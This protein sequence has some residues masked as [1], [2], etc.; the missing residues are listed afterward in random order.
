MKK[1]LLIIVLSLCSTFVK[2]ESDFYIDNTLSEEKQLLNVFKQWEQSYKTYT[3]YY[4]TN[5]HL[6]GDTD[7]E[8]EYFRLEGILY[9][10]ELFLASVYRYKEFE[11]KLT[12]L[13]EKNVPY[14]QMSYQKL[15]HWKSWHQGALATLNTISESVKNKNNNYSVILILM[16][17]IAQVID[18]ERIQMQQ[19]QKINF[20]LVRQ[21]NELAAHK[22][23]LKRWSEQ[24]K[25]EI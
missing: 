4:D 16:D 8:K 11:K 20:Y 6:R 17:R 12:T 2:A 9:A 15:Q 22:R 14:N 19:R 13:S 5:Q 10:A 23:Q 25:K 18:G 3:N 24:L 1:L 7:L 21:Q